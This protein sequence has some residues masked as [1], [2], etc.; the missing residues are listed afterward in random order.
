M[1]YKEFRTPLIL[2]KEI[3][4]C[5]DEFRKKHWGDIIPVNIEFII[6][7]KIGIDIIP[8]PGLKDQCNTDAFISSDWQSVYVDNDKYLEDS[9]YNRLRFSIAH[10]IGHSV[11]HKELYESLRIESFEDFRK[12]IGEAPGIQYSYI[13]TQA[14]K[15]ANYF[16]VPRNILAVK[17]EII[18]SQYAEIRSIDEAQI[19]SYIATPLSKEF[20]V[21]PE[22]MEIALNSD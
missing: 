19:N 17:R 11:L 18:I 13:E 20:G 16:L 5:A 15:F 22:A 12:F 4:R 10:E 6:E 14:N 1:D 3:K 2:N 7:N 9:Y 21:S 8:I